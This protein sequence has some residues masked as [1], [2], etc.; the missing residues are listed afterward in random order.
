M[1]LLTVRNLAL[2][3]DGRCVIEHLNFTLEP[4]DYL[5]IVG[6]NGSGKSTLLHGLLSL[7]P[8]TQGEI[9]WDK[10]KEPAYLPQ[11]TKQQRDFPASV[12]EVVRTGCLNRRKLRIFP[13]PDEHE[14]VE[15]NLRRF[16]IESLRR[17]PYAELSGGQQQRVLLARALC[18]SDK[19]LLLDEPTAGL[20]PLVSAELYRLIDSL[21]DGGLT[22]IMVT[23]DLAP[24]LSSA[25][26]IL[27]LGHKSY[28][29]G[30]TE[31]YL[32]SPAGC[33]FAGGTIS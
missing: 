23:H 26:H 4:G 8:P 24:A 7:L 2:A 16:G 9:L 15:A 18:A 6:E 14:R 5:C 22:V 19:I 10:C 27:H 32:Q 30:T 17:R 12:E 1:P 20:D 29:F 33:G 3:Y 28:W 25:S 21:R 11:Q 13:L 31:D